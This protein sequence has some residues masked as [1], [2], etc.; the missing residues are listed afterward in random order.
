[1]AFFLRDGGGALDRFRDGD[2]VALEEVYRA[3]FQTVSRA[4]ARTLRRYGEGESGHD[5][6]AVAHDLPD[7]V[8]EVF[9]R[10][11]EPDTR[12]RF[13]GVREYAPYLAQIARNVVVDHLRRQRRQVPLESIGQLSDDGAAVD[14]FAD[15]ETMGTVKTYL[16][17]LPPTLRQIHQV[18]Y[19]DGMSQREAAAALGLGRQA[20]RTLEARL[21]EGLRA[22]L[23]KMR[24]RLPQPLPRL[25]RTATGDVKVS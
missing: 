4:V 11:F 15:R 18:M 16:A 13:D 3:Y 22:A 9:R 25:A 17:S 19:V 24:P 12:R 20:V 10:A 5:W 1:M 6:R 7:L 14:A 23:E 2:P 8:Q 21:R